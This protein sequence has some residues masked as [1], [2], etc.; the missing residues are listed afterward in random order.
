MERLQACEGFEWDEGNVDKNWL[1]HGV[2]AG[3]CEQIFFNQPLLVDEDAAHSQEEERWHAL[4]RTAA[5]RRHFVV[6]TVRAKK[7]R[8]ISARPM[9]YKERAIHE[10]LV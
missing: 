4:G 2:T 8:V 7:I 3:E 9:S 1:K 5:G 6:F 10:R